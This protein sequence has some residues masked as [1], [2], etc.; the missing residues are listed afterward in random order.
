MTSFAYRADPGRHLNL[1]FRI[2]KKDYEPGSYLFCQ[3]YKHEV[4]RIL[5]ND[6]EKFYVLLMTIF[7][8]RKFLRK[9]KKK[10]SV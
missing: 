10:K 7:L 3:D 1:G 4:L 2:C 6:L 5:E 8:K 9:T